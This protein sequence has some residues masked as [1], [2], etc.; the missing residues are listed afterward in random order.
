M[1]VRFD[2]QGQ[3]WLADTGQ[4]IDLSIAV[5]FHGPQPVFFDRNPASAEALQAGGFVGDTGRGGSC[6]VDT[7]HFTP[8]CHG[9]HTECISHV[10]DDGPALHTLVASGPCLAQLITVDPTPA[11]FSDDDYICELSSEEPIIARD[12]L[13]RLLGDPLPDGVEALIIRTLPNSDDK[14]GRDYGRQPQYPILSTQAM[15]WLSRQHGL[16]HLLL[17]TPS[18]DYGDDGGRLN[19]HRL[20]W[21]LKP[22]QKN[23]DTLVLAHRSI[24]EMIY[25][26]DEVIDGLYLLDLQFPALASD[27]APSRPLIYPLKPVDT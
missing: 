10:V 11:G 18:A 15:Q 12:D 22:G 20:F 13:V 19:N 4:V 3:Q 17:D 27:A 24:T 21:N 26:P 16:K 23:L 1:L 9:T 2:H 25:V 6:N 7:L 5:D 8:H 14:R